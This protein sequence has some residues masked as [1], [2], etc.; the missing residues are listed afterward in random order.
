MIKFTILIDCEFENKEEIIQLV[1]FLL[2]AKTAMET[3]YKNN[4]ITKQEY[5]LYDSFYF[6]ILSDLMKKFYEEKL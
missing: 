3:N 2:G 4:K 6:S 1:G 5:R